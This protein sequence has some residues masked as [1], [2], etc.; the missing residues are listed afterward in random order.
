[1]TSV[2]NETAHVMSLPYRQAKKYCFVSASLSYATL[3]FYV[4]KKSISCL[5]S[6]HYIC[7]ASWREEVWLK[8]K[9][10]LW[11]LQ[12]DDLVLSRSSPRGTE[13]NGSKRQSL[14]G[15]DKIIQKYKT[16]SLVLV[17]RNM[18]AQMHLQVLLFFKKSCNFYFDNSILNFFTWSLLVWPRRTVSEITTE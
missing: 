12:F 14:H 8:R 2:C 5:F 17:E 16:H 7:N 3:F 18:R 9:R 11:P 6:L 15:K 13:N 1:M 10:G 4:L